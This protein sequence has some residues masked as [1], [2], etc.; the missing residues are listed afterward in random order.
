MRSAS[1]AAGHS[2]RVWKCMSTE[3]WKGETCVRRWRQ[4]ELGGGRLGRDRAVAL[5]DCQVSNPIPSCTL[6]PGVPLSAC[7]CGDA[8]S[9]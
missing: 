5:H 8:P 2:G 3:A 6:H 1:S 9:R 4:G 7:A